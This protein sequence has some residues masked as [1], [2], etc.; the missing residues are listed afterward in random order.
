MCP[1]TDEHCSQVVRTSK[2]SGMVLFHSW[3]L[4]FAHSMSLNV[5]LSRMMVAVHD[6]GEMRSKDPA[7]TKV[8]VSPNHVPVNST[9]CRNTRGQ[10]PSS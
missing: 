9:S 4:V 3:S 8:V 10:P 2:E 7:R 1:G 6:H 5:S